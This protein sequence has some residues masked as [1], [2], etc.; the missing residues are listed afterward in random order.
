MVLDA[1]TGNDRKLLCLLGF[2]RACP[3]AP[4]S[5]R[6]ERRDLEFAVRV[7]HL[8][9]DGIAAALDRNVGTRV[10]NA[11]LAQ[12]HLVEEGREMRIAQP[13]LPRGGVDLEAEGGL[14][15]AER[16]GG[17]PRL[18]RA[19]DRIERRPAPAGA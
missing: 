14:Q 16:G 11:D 15:E 10:V 7:E 1:A 5:S 6:I 2:A 3:V 17:R 19:G 18:R 4:A 13:Y 9:R 8:H 12:D